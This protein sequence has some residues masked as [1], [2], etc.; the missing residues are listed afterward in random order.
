MSVV[1]R[2]RKNGDGTTSLL[3]DIYHNGRRT[4][5]FLRLLKLIKPVTALEREDNKQ[6]LKLAH[7][8]KNKKEQLLQSDDYDVTPDF[9][10]TI[11]F[12]EYYQSYS[13]RYSRKDKRLMDASFNKFKLF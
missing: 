9:K 1:L 12:I 8:I 3:L 10:K 11:N 4:Y 2:K 5:E 7:Q 6:R 13:T